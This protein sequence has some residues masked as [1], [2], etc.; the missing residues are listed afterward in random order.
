SLFAISAIPGNNMAY[1]FSAYLPEKY[2]GKVR[3]Y[4]WKINGL[5]IPGE[6]ETTQYTFSNAGNYKVSTSA[7]IYCDTCPSLII[8]CNE[9]DLSVDEQ[10]IVSN[11]APAKAEFTNTESYSIGWN[12]SPLYFDY[13]ESFLRDDAKRTLDQN[14]SI[15]KENL[16]L[17]LV[18]NGY[19]D[20]R[21]TDEYNKELSSRRVGSVKNYL[22]K[23]G[24]SRYRI[25][26]TIAYGESMI[27]NGCV[28]DVECSEEKH[29][30]NRKVELKISNSKVLYT[31]VS[32]H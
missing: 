23:S 10:G 29:Q 11:D 5:T 6:T 19:A 22:L 27:E 26:G 2:N 17:T 30:E 15:L 31:K 18:I 21:G 4:N 16:D 9:R 7:V 32:M 28:D 1:T 3:S 24:I 13:D 8:V 20:A 25:T 12:M 14:V